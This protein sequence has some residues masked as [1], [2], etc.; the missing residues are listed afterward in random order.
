M[1]PTIEQSQAFQNAFDYFNRELFNGELQTPM[2]TLTRNAQIL[3]GYF[4]PE[5]WT[6]NGQ[7]VSEIAIN[8]NVMNS[9]N[10]IDLMGT[11]VHEMVHVW[12]HYQ[13]TPSRNGYHNKE[14]SDKCLSIGIKPFNV[15]EPEK[16]TGQNCDHEIMKGQDTY[17]AI[18][19]LP[20]DCLFPYTTENLGSLDPQQGGQG[21]NPPPTPVK[22][23][24][25]TKYTCPICGMNVWGKSGLVI[26]CLQCNQTLIEQLKQ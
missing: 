8:A 7:K 6:R 3:G 12:Q 24:Q 22:P 19:N 13:G 2:L 23:G 20:D 5:K 15:K 26:A 16:T 17:K 14:W 1:K 11:L 25:R 10:L 4:I 21:Q 9:G 18:V